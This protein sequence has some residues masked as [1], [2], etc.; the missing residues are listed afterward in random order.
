MI[1]GTTVGQRL[2]RLGT[3]VLS[4]HPHMDPPADREDCYSATHPSDHNSIFINSRVGRQRRE[5]RK[6]IWRR[7]R[8]RDGQKVQDSKGK[9]KNKNKDLEERYARGQGH[10]AAFMIPVPQTYGYGSPHAY[11]SYPGSCAVVVSPCSPVHPV[12]EG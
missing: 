12:S 4:H 3:L 8:N 9:P 6:L 11:P 2:S 10:G 5:L 1:Q 7:R